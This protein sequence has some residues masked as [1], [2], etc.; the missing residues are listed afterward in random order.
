[1]NPELLINQQPSYYMMKDGHIL[2]LEHELD[3]SDIPILIKDNLLEQQDLYKLNQD[4]ANYRVAVYRD[5]IIELEEYT[6][7]VYGYC[8]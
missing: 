7:L 8:V 3:P 1:M 4:Q 2:R 5:E 6:Q